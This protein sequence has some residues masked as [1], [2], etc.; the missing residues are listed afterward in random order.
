M[1]YCTD[2][3]VQWQINGHN[4]MHYEYHHDL[5]MESD[6]H[7]NKESRKWGHGSHN[8]SLL[9]I[10]NIIIICFY[11]FFINI[12]NFKWFVVIWLTL[13]CNATLMFSVYFYDNFVCLF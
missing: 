4:S 6:K 2:A 7:E 5:I 10:Y 12:S 3:K 1:N 9:Y 11:I 8:I 13:A